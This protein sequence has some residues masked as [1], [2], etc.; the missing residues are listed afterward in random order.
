MLLHR[1]LS[2]ACVLSLGAAAAQAQNRPP[3]TPT[4]RSPTER[5]SPVPGVTLPSG[6][7]QGKAEP[8]PVATEVRPNGV[9][10]QPKLPTGQ[11]T[12]DSVQVAPAQ[13]QRATRPARRTRP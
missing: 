1:F 12:V 8:L 5:I 4:R 2:F 7:G 6:V 3:V 13:P 10:A 9:L 11:V